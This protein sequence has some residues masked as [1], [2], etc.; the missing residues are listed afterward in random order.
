MKILCCYEETSIAKDALRE[1]QKHADVWGAT[2]DVLQVVERETPIKH[3]RL[4]TMETQ[5]KEN[6][7]SLFEGSGLNYRVILKVG[8]IDKGEEIVRMAKRQE[9]DL[10]FIGIKKY[11]RVGKLVFGSTVR[12]VI[13]NARCPV[14]TINKNKKGGDRE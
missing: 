3:E 13:L 2:I 9:S 10:I 5:L 8:D 12:T 1:A 11:S 7:A 6:V 4:E 14:V